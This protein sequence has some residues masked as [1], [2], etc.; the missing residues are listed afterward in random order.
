MVVLR[1]FTYYDQDNLLGYCYRIPLK[2]YV[3]KRLSVNLTPS[4]GQRANRYHELTEG[5]DAIPRFVTTL[6]DKVADD[7]NGDSWS[8]KRYIRTFKDTL[9]SGLYG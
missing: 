2:K 3:V 8:A 7:R 4:R 9:L 5:E 6:L 1:A